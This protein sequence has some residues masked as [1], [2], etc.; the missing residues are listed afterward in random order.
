MNKNK[1]E[2]RQGTENGWRFLFV[3]AQTTGK[4]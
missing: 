3:F 2:W 4:G 1:P